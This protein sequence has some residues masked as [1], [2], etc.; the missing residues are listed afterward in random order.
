MSAATL[1][2]LPDSSQ[3]RLDMIADQLGRTNEFDDSGIS[4]EDFDGGQ[5]DEDQADVQ[6]SDE[7]PADF[8]KHLEQRDAFKSHLMSLPGALSVRFCKCTCTS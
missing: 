4:E 1:H 7:T 8:Q 5:L 3:N 6:Q 2:Q